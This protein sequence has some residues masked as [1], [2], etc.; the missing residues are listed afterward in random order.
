MVSG[1]GVWGEELHLVEGFRICGCR[2]RVFLESSG[3]K[4]RTHLSKHLSQT[5]TGS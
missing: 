5:L 1:L 3:K 2:V 4:S